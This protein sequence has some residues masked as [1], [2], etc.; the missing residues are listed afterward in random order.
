MGTA[1][2]ESTVIKEINTKLIRDDVHSDSDS[3][4]NGGGRTTAARQRR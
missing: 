4:S 1:H 2:L 3:D